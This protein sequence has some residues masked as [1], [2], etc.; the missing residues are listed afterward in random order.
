MHYMEQWWI[1]GMISTHPYHELRLK[2]PNKM[3]KGPT[4]HSSM[5][6]FHQKPLMKQK[7]SPGSLIYLKRTI[8]CQYCVRKEQKWQ[9]SIES[10]YNCCIGQIETSQIASQNRFSISINL[11]RESKSWSSQLWV[12]VGSSMS[13]F[14]PRTLLIFFSIEI[15]PELKK[16][17][18]T[19]VAFTSH[20]NL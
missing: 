19:V 17:R 5:N 16:N 1:L 12:W 7:V 9:N 18:L 10:P 6:L 11:A 3:V 8:K 2:G 15:N 14:G 13:L 20:A 4:W